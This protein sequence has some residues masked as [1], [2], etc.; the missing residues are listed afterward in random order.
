MRSTRHPLTPLPTHRRPVQISLGTADFERPQRARA[1]VKG[2]ISSPSPPQEGRR[3]PLGSHHR[4]PPRD[5]PARRAAGR[6]A[7]RARSARPRLCPD[8]ASDSC[9]RSGWI[10]ALAAGARGIGTGPSRAGASRD[11]SAE[12]HTP[13]AA[14]GLLLGRTTTIGASGDLNELDIS[15]DK[16]IDDEDDVDATAPNSLARSLARAWTS[17]EAVPS[18]RRHRIGRDGPRRGGVRVRA[19][20]RVVRGGLRPRTIHHPGAGETG[21]LVHLRRWRRSPVHAG[22]DAVFAA[23]T[24]R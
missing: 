6:H 11:L 7:R 24:A 17:T 12:M 14:R 16:D 20:R 22:A 21:A 23:P 5:D 1:R 8:P 4:G 3:G 9:R 15:F 19:A 10:W 18:V 2:M 13:D